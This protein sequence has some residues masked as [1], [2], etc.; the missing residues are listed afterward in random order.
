MTSRPEHYL[1][2]HLDRVVYPAL[3]GRLGAAF[4]EFGW[5][6]SGA[7]WVATRC[8]DGFPA[9][10]VRPDRITAYP[11]NLRNLI[12]QGWGAV[13]FLDLAAPGG[14]AREREA[15]K[16][17]VRRLSELAG[18]EY[19]ERRMSPEAI[20]NAHRREVRAS[21]LE[22]VAAYC[23][24]ALQQ[25]Q[26]AIAREYLKT[27]GVSPAA[28]EE[29]GLGLYPTTR[30][31]NALL[32][33][34]GFATEEINESG[35]VFAPLAG[36]LVFPWRDD[37]G[38]LAT[39]AGRWPGAKSAAPDGKRL[40]GL[41][42]A[43]S[44][45]SPLYLD[46][47][48][49]DGGRDVVL[50]EGLLDALV[51]QSLGDHRVIATG[52]G[53]VT[54]DQVE[55][56]QRRQPRRVYIVGDPDEAGATGNTT[57]A[58]KI[59][60]AGLKAFVAPRLPDG[61]DPDEYALRHGVEAWRDLVS[62]S[63]SAARHLAMEIVKG[64]TPDSPEPDRREAVAR[65]IGLCEL[66]LV[67]EMRHLDAVE[68]HEVIEEATGYP[69]GVI[70]AMERVWIAQRLEERA[71]RAASAA[72]A[73]ATKDIEAEPHRTS[74]IASELR[75]ALSR[76]EVVAQRPRPYT[77]EEMTHAIRLLPEG[78]R[79]GFGGLDDEVAFRP[80]E[81]ALI[82]ARPG[83]AKTSTLVHLLHRWASE[84]RG[85]VVFVSYEET[86]EA[87]FCR[88][89][90]RLCHDIDSASM[91]TTAMVRDW[92]RG[93]AD[94]RERWGDPDTLNTA[95]EHHRGLEE[96]VRVVYAP[97]YSATEA[98]GLVHDIASTTPVAA[99]LCD[100]LQKVKP[101]R[102]AAGERRDIQVTAVAN[103]LRVGGVDLGVPVVAGAQ[104][105]REA[106]P[107]GYSARVRKATSRDEIEAEIRTTRPQLHNLREGGSEPE[108]DLVLGLLNYDADIPK[109]GETLIDSA[110]LDVGVLKNRYG[111]VGRWEE[112][113][114]TGGA[115][116]VTPRRG[117]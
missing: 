60:S 88:L 55:T 49:A 81:L 8:P 70:G 50:V 101:D 47:A 97:R 57:T 71:Q 36:Y 59:L 69:A 74:E 72:I 75:S 54:A 98:I 117:W 106:I 27:R 94:A 21:V 89:V 92:I 25:P 48:L 45:R 9:G 78:L 16:A 29:F 56:L 64:I 108:A 80:G 83:H 115:S 107:E 26:G 51:L 100:Y 58:T 91:W 111:R 62:S 99:I 66:Q 90:A 79:G 96:F 67:G 53:A 14:N 5:K 68:I 86:M 23:A 10:E 76:V 7:N 19:P 39:L 110:R 105:N 30:E 4:P 52:G 40:H 1:N 32:A 61:L 18:V 44:K 104:I 31:I 102:S 43:G 63:I 82:A 34:K 103:T 73:A 38:R 17:A 87:I 85:A 46:R 113:T 42:G 114:F 6:R 2:D 28:I 3:H 37:Q 20:E 41:P 11:N 35:A 13:R 93:G 33:G 15:Y 22:E 109:D 84:R 116:L 77:V 65:G 12:V 95:I 24:D 112:M